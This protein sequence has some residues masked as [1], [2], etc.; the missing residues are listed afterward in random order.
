MWSCIN[1]KAVTCPCCVRFLQTSVCW[2]KLSEILSNITFISSLHP[3]VSICLSRDA[4]CPLQERLAEA[5]GSQCG[6]CTPGFVMSMYALLRSSKHPPTEEQIEDSLAGNLCRCT[7]YRPIIDAFRVFAK[8]DDSLYTAS[9]SEKAN[10]QAICHSTGKPCS[11]RNE[12]DVNA[13]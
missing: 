1:Y 12:T 3:F 7:G 5:H 10:G 13:N 11:C 2:E 9:P 6:F 4:V 8:T